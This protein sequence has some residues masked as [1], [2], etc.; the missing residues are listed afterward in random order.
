MTLQITDVV[1]V[2][3]VCSYFHMMSNLEAQTKQQLKK[4]VVEQ[5]ELESNIFLLARDNLTLLRNRLLQELKRDTGS[6]DI[7]FEKLYFP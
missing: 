1:I 2:S 6:D 5:G 4:Y 3:A 7:E